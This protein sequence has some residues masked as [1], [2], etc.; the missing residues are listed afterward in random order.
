MEKLSTLNL[1]FDR[2]IIQLVTPGLIAS[3]P[4]ILLFFQARPDCEDFFLSN[5]DGLLIA[6]LIIIGLI[7]GLLLENIGSRIEVHYY[8]ERQKKEDRKFIKTW[9]KFL[10]LQIKN[11]EDK[12][13]IGLSYTRN[14]VFRMKFELSAGVALLLMAIGLAIYD[15]NEVIFENCI[16]NT[17][18]IYV[19]PI[20]IS[21]YLLLV[22]GYSSAKVLAQT[23]KLLVKKYYPK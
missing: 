13:P 1:T 4:Y 7:V 6:F 15:H 2:V 17:F 3:Y 16:V 19:L 11:N 12:E 21:A 14:I 5:K 9:Q 22:E 20:G 10:Q 8:D 23:R 18:F